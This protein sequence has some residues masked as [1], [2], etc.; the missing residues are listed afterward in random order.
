MK[1]KFKEPKPIAERPI[2]S[3]LENWKL[4]YSQ[5]YHILQKIPNWPRHSRAVWDK[6]VL[7][8]GSSLGSYRGL[9]SC[10]CLLWLQIPHGL[11]LPTAC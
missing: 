9:V 3:S 5:L 1:Q 2:Y 6:G 8:V 11:E 10:L 4:I 7:D